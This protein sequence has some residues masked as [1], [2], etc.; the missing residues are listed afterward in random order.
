[1]DLQAILWGKEK[2]LEASLQDTKDVLDDIVS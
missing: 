1:M 2:N